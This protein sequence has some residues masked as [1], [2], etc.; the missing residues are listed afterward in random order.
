MRSIKL[1]F[2]LMFGIFLVSVASV[3]ATVVSAGLWSNGQQSM[4]ITY[5]QD[6]TFS[7]LLGGQT[8]PSPYSM[9]VIIK[10]YDSSY[11]PLY[12][13]ENKALSFNALYGTFAQNYTVTS[14]MYKSPGNYSVVIQGS[15]SDGIDSS[16][17]MLTVKNSPPS[18]VSIPNQALDEGSSYVYQ[19]A[20]SDADGDTLT[21]SLGSSS[22]SWLSIN[23][24]TG[25]I[26]GTLPSVS[27]DTNY[28]V[29]VIVSDGATPSVTQSYILTVKFIPPDVIPPS[30]SLSSPSDNFTSNSDN[31]V[32]S[33]IAS[34]NVKLA[35]VSLI[36]NGAINQT[37]SSGINNT[38]YSFPV[39]L[40]DGVYNWSFNA[41]DSSGNC[42]NSSVRKLI[43]DTVPPSIQIENSTSEGNLS[44]SFIS[45]SLNASDNLSGVKNIQVYLYNSTGLVEVKSSLSSSFSMN[46]TGL[47]D[48]NYYFNA[49][50][51]DNA[52]NVNS[53][54]N[55]KVTLDTVPPEIQFVNA[56]PSD[57]ANLNQSYI[58][59]NVTASDSGTGVEKIIIFLYNSSGLVGE[60]TSSYFNFT[61]LNNGVYYVNA[62]AYD[63]AENS[64]NTPTIKITLKS[65]TS[66]SNPTQSNNEGS[67]SYSYSDVY[68]TQ[69]YQEQ[70]NKTGQGI[71]L[72][73][74]EQ[75][76]SQISTG[77]IAL[78]ASL[79][80]VIAG[81]AFLLFRVGFSP[82][83]S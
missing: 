80:V 7:A 65:S 75:A 83:R 1:L 76:I 9:S 24:S 13:F 61:S 20:A 49:T 4:T 2:L 82:K 34:D 70:M 16:T 59:V 15:D 43:V 54:I 46:F 57:G 47:A 12:T 72:G 25:L 55:V 53:I 32:F 48:G 22:P 38:S 56:T 44:Q 60:E 11:N 52:G 35:N 67:S 5:G 33:G 39:S 79:I 6:A 45:I 23:S 14:S 73:P 3:S 10:L 50:A 41:C 66:S 63:F 19:A 81:V 17:L 31:I 74:T 58:P 62:T 77:W 28:T 8:Y 68:S 21:Y 64:K 18:L 26:T 51:E 71:S 69:Q 42:A 29:D 37:N 78:V 36:I 40:S 27:S 30:V